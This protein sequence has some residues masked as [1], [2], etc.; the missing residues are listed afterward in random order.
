VASPPASL[1]RCSRSVSAA[2]CGWLDSLDRCLLPLLDGWPAWLPCACWLEAG[3]FLVWAGNQGLGSLWKP[4][5]LGKMNP[6]VSALDGPF[7]PLVWIGLVWP[8]VDVRLP[9]PL[10]TLMA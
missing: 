5:A 10:G 7:H 2:M 1:A 4:L 3:W 9:G 6:R 8:L